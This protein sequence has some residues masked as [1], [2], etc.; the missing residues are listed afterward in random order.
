MSIQTR[1]TSPFLAA[2]ADPVLR[3]LATAALVNTLGRGVFLTL[4]ILYLTL[5]VG[6]PA[7]AVAVVLTVA[8][9]VGVLT[10]VVA[11]HLADHLSAKLLLIVLV[12]VEGCALIAFAWSPAV[13]V[14]TALA[15]VIVG[16][17]RASNA[18]RSAIIAR[19]FDGASRAETRALIRTVSNAGIA[20]GSAAAGIPVVVGTAAG[21][22]IAFILAGCATLAGAVRLFAL[23][24]SVDATPSSVIAPDAVTARPAGKSP[25]LDVR[26]LALTLFAG[27]FAMQFGV[28]EVGLPI[29]VVS[30]TSAPQVIVSIALIVN[31]LGVILLQIPMS[32]GAESIRRAGNMTG[33]AGIL[34]AAACFAY[35]GAAGIAAPV[36]VTL[37]L[38]AV[39]LHTFAEILSSAGTWSLSFELAD[40][41]RPG[42]YQGVFG[43]GFAL[44]S[45]LAPL[46]VTVTA[47]DHKTFGWAILAGI[48]LVSALAVRALTRFADRRAADSPEPSSSPARQKGSEQTMPA[49]PSIRR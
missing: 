1:R 31:T 4:T 35:S 38:G 47:L 42:A 21:Y 43:M 20:L 25:F 41:S 34:M 19:A 15:A 32:R 24:R 14:V 33:L 9:G 48:F 29:W 36:A 10:S 7:T 49:P 40:R 44:G 45:M 3:I 2:L 12:A 17:N 5:F 27:I 8:S 11:G 23:P 13:V 16:A 46:V 28:A 26:Y 37:L 30:D 18:V 22:R 39:L 6:L